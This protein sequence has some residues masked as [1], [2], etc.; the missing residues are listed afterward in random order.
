MKFGNVIITCCHNL[1][2]IV[3]DVVGLHHAN[4]VE[5]RRISCREAAWQKESEPA[6]RLAIGYGPIT[7]ECPQLAVSGPWAAKLLSGCY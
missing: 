2:D 5:L 7:R 4:D 1:T 6:I 3:A